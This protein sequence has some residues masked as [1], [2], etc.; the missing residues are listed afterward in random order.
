MHLTPKTFLITCLVLP[1]LVAGSAAHGQTC[2]PAHL[3]VPVYLEAGTASVD[4][5]DLPGCGSDTLLLGALEEPLHGTALRVGSEIQYEADKSFW[6]LRSDSLIYRYTCAS[7]PL[8]N[9]RGLVQFVAGLAATT[10]VLDEF[11]DQAPLSCGW[12]P[13]DQEANWSMVEQP[14][15]SNNHW[16]QISQ[17]IS[18]PAFLTMVGTENL[19]G[20]FEWPATCRP[21]LPLGAP[22]E[23]LGE[24]GTVDPCFCMLVN[25]G[26]T[27]DSE[28]LILRA[29]LGSD[30]RLTHH[31][32]VEIYLDEGPE[33][34]GTSPR[35]QARTLSATGEECSTEWA[36]LGDGNAVVRVDVW[37][38]EAGA[39]SGL[40][41]RVNDRNVGLLR[42]ADPEVDRLFKVELGLVE[43]PTGAAPQVDFEDFVIGSRNPKWTLPERRIDTFECGTIADWGSEGQWPPE[44]ASEAALT[45]AYGLRVD[46]GAI[47]SSSPRYGFLQDTTPVSQSTFNIRFRLD[48]HTV[49]L[50]NGNSV[51]LVGA[52]DRDT[53]SGG[54]HLR[55]KL[56]G[57]G[58]NL[59]LRAEAKNDAGTYQTT[60]WTALTAGVHTIELQWSASSGE[61]ANSGRVRL[62]VDGQQR[63]EEI[64]ID[65]FGWEVES[66]RV[67]GIWAPV[68][69]LGVIYIDDVETWD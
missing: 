4:E 8:K 22:G 60:D 44:V 18:Q 59:E 2:E 39:G 52:S 66:Y 24:F 29:H 26:P 64:G 68:N 47:A 23:P 20:N 12:T 67:G 43:M 57:I 58:G 30:S 21:E 16:L 9:K 55:L 31:Q 48:T 42:C 63:G 17:G 1:F 38:N 61:W 19:D 45:G 49:D 51:T 50:V 11:D 6:S 35:I 10:L 14:A 40:I 46:L 3:R 27:I 41:L 25:V 7:E 53:P 54:E 32:P 65:N 34:D 15:G 69:A 56:R 62:W 28:V 37:G 33:E 36:E 13:N 5:L